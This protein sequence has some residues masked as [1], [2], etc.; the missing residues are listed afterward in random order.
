MIYLLH[1]RMN[2]DRACM[3]P[4]VHYWSKEGTRSSDLDPHVKRVLRR[5]DMDLDR[6]DPEERESRKL[7]L[8][9]AIVS[10][11]DDV[12][13]QCMHYLR[14]PGRPHHLLLDIA[15]SIHTSSLFPFMPCTQRDSNDRDLLLP[16]VVDTAVVGS[17][18]L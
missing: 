4:R 16:V 2:G 13:V 17:H 5:C 14:L 11:K 8:T 10:E 9:R 18:W 3:R 7:S 15:P 6:P 1:Q 12:R